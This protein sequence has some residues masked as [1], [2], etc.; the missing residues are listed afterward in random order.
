M[1]IIFWCEFPEKVNLALLNKILSRLNLNINV[2]SASKS[3]KEFNNFKDRFSKIKNIKTIGCWPVLEKNKGYWFS[4]FSD[5]DSLKSIL[6]YKNLKLKI[7]IEPP[8]E[9][10]K[11]SYFKIG[12]YFLKYILFKKA[13]NKD[14][15]SEILMNFKKEDLI[16][17][18]FPLP[19]FL[20]NKL[21]NIQDL[22]NSNLNLMCYSTLIPK[23]LRPLYRVYFKYIVD[24]YK[25]IS[26][27]IAAVGL[28][29]PGIF[30]NEPIYIDLKEFKKDLEFIKTLNTNTIVIFELSGV[31]KRKNPE[32][33]F[34]ILNSLQ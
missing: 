34:K 12:F 13:Q 21:I 3:L 6:Q 31:L 8:L 5:K 28:I 24:N 19:K 11:F 30:G 4:G 16:I 25:R 9:D 7:D 1:N 33:W 26:N 2:Y 17:S 10:N 23:I 29:S 18:T 27:V 22:K 15:L 20:L 14:L 32:E